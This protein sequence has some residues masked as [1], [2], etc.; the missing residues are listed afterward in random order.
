MTGW[1]FIFILVA[2]CTMTS[3]LFHVLDAMERPAR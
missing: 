2:V 1:N 3:Q